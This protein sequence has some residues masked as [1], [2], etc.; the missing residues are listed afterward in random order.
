MSLQAYRHLLRA[1]R[2][3]FQGDE[4]TLSAARQQIRASF[5]EKAALSASDPAVAPAVQHA[6]DVAEFLRSNVVQG[7]R[8]ADGDTY[9]EFW[10]LVF[11]FLYL[12]YFCLHLLHTVGKEGKKC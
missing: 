2:I 12:C 6:Q 8:E 4:R 3:A 1:T 5:R 9:S 11:Y 7:K 10:A